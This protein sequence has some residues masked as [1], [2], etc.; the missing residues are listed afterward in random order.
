ME[1]THL[2]VYGI[3]FV[4]QLFFSARTLVQWI[5]SERQKQVVSPSLFWILSLAGS[6]LLC[7]Y[8]WLRDDFSIVLGQFLSYYIYLWNL[9]VKGIWRKIPR[10]VRVL[11]VLT[12]VAAAGWMVHDAGAFVR[13]FL[14]N[15]EVPLALLLCQDQFSERKLALKLK[16]D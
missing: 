4:A 11:I 5:L 8:G 3:G 9:D 12:P 2:L 13:E 15:E 14:R 10:V 6:Y 1:T 16:G 7:L